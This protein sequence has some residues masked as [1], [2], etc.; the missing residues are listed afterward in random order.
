M[1]RRARRQDAQHGQVQAG[2]P[3]NLAKAAAAKESARFALG[4]DR[5]DKA[6]ALVK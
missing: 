6:L 1:S 3:V 5:F 2:K 4:K